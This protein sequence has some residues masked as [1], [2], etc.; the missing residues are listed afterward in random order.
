MEVQG[1][2][3]HHRYVNILYQHLLASSIEVLIIKKQISLSNWTMSLTDR[4]TG[5]PAWWLKFAT[6]AVTWIFHTYEY[7]RY[8]NGMHYAQI[9]E[10]ATFEYFI[11]LSLYPTGLGEITQGY[12]EV[13]IHV[14]LIGWQNLTMRKP[15]QQNFDGMCIRTIVPG[16]SSIKYIANTF[17]AHNISLKHREWLFSYNQVWRRRLRYIIA[18]NMSINTVLTSPSHKL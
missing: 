11:S 10:R 13:F 9:D 17:Y 18:R 7:N 5:F 8:C 14:C 12:C 2:T 15:A 6:G 3:D 16:C 4:V 1:K